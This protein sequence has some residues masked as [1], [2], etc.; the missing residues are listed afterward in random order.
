[1]KA[2]NGIEAGFIVRQACQTPAV[3]RIWLSARVST[4]GVATLALVMLTSCGTEP[5]TPE[6]RPDSLV[7]SDLAALSAPV[8]LGGASLVA[9][10][11]AY[12][13]APA[14]SFST[15]N[16][17]IVRLPEAGFSVQVSMIDGGIDPVAI[18]AATG[19]AITVEI[20]AG[21]GPIAELL[22]IVPTSRRPRVIRTSPARRKTDVPLNARMTIVFSEPVNGATVNAQTIRL[23]RGSE[24]VPGTVR[25]LDPS[26]DATGLSV[27]FV[28][29]AALL[30][31]SAYQLVIASSIR[32]FDGETLDVTEPVEFNTGTSS[33]GPPAVV[34]LSPDV[35]VA[36]PEGVTLQLRATVLDAAGNQLNDQ[37]VQWT[38]T[39][40]SVVTVTQTGR[41]TAMP[42]VAGSSASI[43]ARASQISRSLLVNVTAS[44]PSVPAVLRVVPDT[45]SDSLRVRRRG[46]R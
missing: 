22:G 46:Q 45:A 43:S 18:P 33:V 11:V 36:V 31:N 23:M 21:A 2:L 19:D 20:D 27:E 42:F 4:A 13:A 37:P 12:V 28:P 41:L 44:A 7:V 29:N 38:T 14:S 9:D 10:G 1:M 24:V 25:F 5:S 17:A 40:D 3:P 35:E 34:R 39:N 32:D 16:R 26:I 6:S 8:V 15:G 30:P